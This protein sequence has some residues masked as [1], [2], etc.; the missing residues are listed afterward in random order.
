MQPRRV[1]HQLIGDCQHCLFVLSSAMLFF[2]VDVV[3]KSSDR[4]KRAG[5]WDVNRLGESK[6]AQKSAKERQRNETG[7]ERDG[8]R[9]AKG[10]A[11]K[12]RDR[13][14][15]TLR[16]DRISSSPS[17]LSSSLLASQPVRSR[18]GTISCFALLVVF[19]TCVMSVRPSVRQQCFY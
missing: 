10:T 8:A 18:A 17:P 19:A 2:V 4:R 11:R 3:S 1:M 7:R 9:K 13:G 14:R 15:R 12:K 6:R 5:P 16:S